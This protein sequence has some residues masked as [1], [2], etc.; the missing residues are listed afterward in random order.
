LLSANKNIYTYF[1]APA[2]VDASNKKGF[3]LNANDKDEKHVVQAKQEIYLY[4]Q[5]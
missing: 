5:G 4:P 1:L 3:S 2:I